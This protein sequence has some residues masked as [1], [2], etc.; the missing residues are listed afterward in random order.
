MA[1]R[2]PIFKPHDVVDTDSDGKSGEL[3]VRR[4]LT[5]RQMTASLLY[6]VLRIDQSLQSLSMLQ[7]VHWLISTYIC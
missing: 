7:V 2:V 1:M 4:S 5:K 3:A 6:I